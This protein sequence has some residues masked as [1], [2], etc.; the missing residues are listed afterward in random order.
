MPDGVER[1]KYAWHKATV[2]ER[3]A[4]LKEVYGPG[5]GD[6]VIDIRAGVGGE[7]LEPF[8]LL[9]WEDRAFQLSPEHAREHALKI[10]D[11]SEAAVH[12]AFLVRWVLEVVGSDRERAFALIQDLRAW[13]QRRAEL[14]EDP[15]GMTG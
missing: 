10:L 4:F 7:T 9:Q 6:Q 2:P 11:A 12:D 1:L 8:V 3:V 14:P 15:E 13:R 5:G